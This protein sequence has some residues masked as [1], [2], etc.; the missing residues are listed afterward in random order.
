M[1]QMVTVINRL[2]EIEGTAVGLERH[3]AEQKKE[4]AAEYEKKTQEFDQEIDAR[5]DEKLRRLQEKLKQ[6]A[7]MELQKMRQ[8]T[9]AELAAM[10]TEYQQN[11]RKL[12]SELFHKMIGE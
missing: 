11:H 1:E 4:I 9:E 10:E 8:K 5:T 6:E 7:E 2:S 12:A 3:A